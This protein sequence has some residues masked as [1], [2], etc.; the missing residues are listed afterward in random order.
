MNKENTISQWLLHK[1]AAVFLLVI[2][3]YIV[4]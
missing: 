1:G 3:S 4:L 2:M